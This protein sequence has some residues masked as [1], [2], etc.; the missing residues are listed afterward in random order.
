[1]LG[2]E[3]TRWLGILTC[4]GLIVALGGRY[5]RMA[6]S[7]PDGVAACLADPAAHDG[8]PL[9]LPVWT[10]TAVDGPRRYHVGRVVRDVVVEGDT[11]GLARGQTITLVGDFR[12]ADAVVVERRREIHHLRPWKTRLSLLGL[13]L[14]T[15]LAPVVFRWRDGYLELR[16]PRRGGAGA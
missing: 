10:V 1:M 15:A 9:V 12:A 14:A 11:R 2:R 16:P 5:G 6:T 13:V 8:T 3:H 4:L 7:L